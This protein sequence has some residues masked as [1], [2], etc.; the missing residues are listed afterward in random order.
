MTYVDQLLPTIRNKNWQY[1]KGCHLFAD[2]DDELVAFA[3]KIGLRR[4]WLQQN[5]RRNHFDLTEGMR[6]KA[7]VAGAVE[8]DRRRVVE[9][10]RRAKP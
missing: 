8:I 1:D 4:E 3:V 10:L 7:V 2:T 9:L 6:K 5:R